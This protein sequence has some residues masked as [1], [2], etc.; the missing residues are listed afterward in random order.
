[1]SHY[2]INIPQNID[3][4]DFTNSTHV[5]KL[6]C[7]YII[8]NKTGCGDPFY[9]YFSTRSDQV[10]T[11]VLLDILD[12]QLVAL[13]AGA[14][15]IH[16][17]IVIMLVVH[18]LTILVCLEDM[19]RTIAG[20]L[21]EDSITPVTLCDIHIL[22]K[23][24]V[25][26]QEDAQ[27]A[28]VIEPVECLAVLHVLSTDELTGITELL[29]V[30]VQ[31]IS[32]VIVNDRIVVML[33]IPAVDIVGQINAHHGIDLLADILPDELFVHTLE[34]IV[35]DARMHIGLQDA[36]VAICVIHLHVA[37]T[38][39]DSDGVADLAV[40]VLIVYDQFASHVLAV[41]QTIV[42]IDHVTGADELGGISNVLD[43]VVEVAVEVVVKQDVHI[44]FSFSLESY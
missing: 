40:T 36:T 20:E 37:I 15:R 16:D 18:R 5:L 26:L 21:D 8:K 43:T 4:I 28:H 23:G 27:V 38:E 10:D 33:D 17:A 3:T 1:M 19:D 35:V 31:V 34:D 25:V 2:G 22:L 44:C 14:M 29:D 9:F 11:K 13:T 42:G 6:L 39:D 12:K 24:A 30:V 41:G 7:I 32:P